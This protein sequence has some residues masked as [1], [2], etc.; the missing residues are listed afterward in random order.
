LE[1]KISASLAEAQY[2]PLK[3][4][5]KKVEAKAPRIRIETEEDAPVGPSEEEESGYLASEVTLEESSWSSTEVEDE[6]LPK[7]EDLN[8]R[9]PPK[10]LGQI[11]ELFRAKFTKV[12]RVSE[13]SLK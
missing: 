11:E 10:V 1:G 8:Q 2:A 3:I 5:V 6:D 12:Q 4:A 9:I 7:M 13:D